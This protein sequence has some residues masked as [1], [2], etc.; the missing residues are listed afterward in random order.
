MPENGNRQFILK[1]RPDGMP[2]ES[3]F[4]FVQSAIPEPE[5]G[6]VLVKNLWMS[7]DPYM[8]GRLRDGP[9]Y[10][11]PVAIGG[12]PASAPP[13]VPMAV[14]APSRMTISRGMAGLMAGA[15]WRGYGSPGVMA[16]APRKCKG[17]GW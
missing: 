2:R 9:S 12:V 15:P 14:R 17:R 7:I 13:K 16:D 10:A 1:T 5:H 11:P 3:D 8:R 6:Q 4:E